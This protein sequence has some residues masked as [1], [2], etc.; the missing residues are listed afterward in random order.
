[1]WKA[2]AQRQRGR[3]SGAPRGCWTTGRG[4]G[5]VDKWSGAGRM[6]ERGLAGQA[7][8]LAT[9]EGRRSNLPPS[10]WVC[11]T[12]EGRTVL[13]FILPSSHQGFTCGLNCVASLAPHTHNPSPRPS[14]VCLQRVLGRHMVSFHPQVLERASAQKA[15]CVAAGWTLGG[16][17]RV[18]RHGRGGVSLPRPSGWHSPPRAVPGSSQ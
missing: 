7:M 17:R 8:G 5:G 10:R 12:P 4:S 6:L 2:L 11:R 9:G 3:S 13:T 18:S 14:L 15:W 16:S 1:M